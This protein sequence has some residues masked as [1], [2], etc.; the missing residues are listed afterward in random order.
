[1]EHPSARDLIEQCSHA[2]EALAWRRF[3]ERYG[4]AIEAGVRRALR[5]SGEVGVATDDLQDLVQEC[6]C[7]LLEGDRRRLTSLRA[8]ADGEVRTWLARFAERSVRDRLK[9]QR[10]YK[11]SGPGR[12]ALAISERAARLA[13][14]TRSPERLAMDRQALRRFA[15]YCRRLSS[16]ER[17]AAILRLVYFAGLTSREVSELS[18]GALSP[19]SVDSVVYRFRQRLARRGL[20]VPLR[21]SHRRPGARYR[22]ARR[23]TGGSSRRR[24]EGSSRPGRHEL[25]S[26]P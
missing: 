5:R 11:R 3:V 21:P 2:P 15:R 7:R 19:S 26:V 17:D 25:Q 16:S 22:T 18:R 9:W 23:R 6:Y 20:P 12:G 24:A 4:P 13:D 8:R 10:A 14:P 1:M